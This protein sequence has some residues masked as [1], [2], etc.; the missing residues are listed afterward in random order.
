MEGGHIIFFQ[1]F[2]QVRKRMW[3]SRKYNS[4]RSSTIIHFGSIVL[5]HGGQ[6]EQVLAGKEKRVLYFP[7]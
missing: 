2:Q 6:V 5:Q 4:E 7:E 1:H 3:G